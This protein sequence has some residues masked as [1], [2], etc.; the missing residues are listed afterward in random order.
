MSGFYIYSIF[1]FMRGTG[2]DD[3]SER[4]DGLLNVTLGYR[5]EDE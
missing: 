2:G 3:L 4:D 5:R 1:S